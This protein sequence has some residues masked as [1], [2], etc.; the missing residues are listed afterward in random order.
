MQNLKSQTYIQLSELETQQICQSFLE[1]R[2]EVVDMDEFIVVF[3]RFEH[4]ATM[5]GSYIVDALAEVY[6]FILVFSP[7]FK[8]YFGEPEGSA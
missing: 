7:K 5:L 3:Q 1:V 6:W 8:Q 2:D 4:D